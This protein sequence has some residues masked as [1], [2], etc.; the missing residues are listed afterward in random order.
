MDRLS[1]WDVMFFME[2]YYVVYIICSYL[3]F[4]L[5]STKEDMI[6]EVSIHVFF[7]I[8]SSA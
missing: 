8:G 7:V 4:G 1:P 5:E 2:H 6:E 3:P